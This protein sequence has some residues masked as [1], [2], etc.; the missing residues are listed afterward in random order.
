MPDEKSGHAEL[1]QPAVPPSLEDSRTDQTNQRDHLSG[2]ENTEQDA[3]ELEVRESRQQPPANG[4]ENEHDADDGENESHR[5]T[6]PFPRGCLAKAARVQRRKRKGPREFAGLTP[7]S[8]F[9]I[10]DSMKRFTFLIIVLGAIGN[11]FA[12]TLLP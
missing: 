1:R 10:L 7:K 11:I 4:I 12:D 6:Y 2:H 5:R 9:V 8:A 3:A